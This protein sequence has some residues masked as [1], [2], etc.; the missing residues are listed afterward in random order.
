[1][2][3]IGLSCEVTSGIDVN[4]EKYGIKDK[5]GKVPVLN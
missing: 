1:M 3:Y 2:E 5:K 4:A